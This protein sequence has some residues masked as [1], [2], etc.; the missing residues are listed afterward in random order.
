MEVQNPTGCYIYRGEIEEITV[1]GSELRV[2][3]ARLAKGQGYPSFP[4]RW[5]RHYDLDLAVNLG[6]YEVDVHNKRQ[7]CLNSSDVGESIFLFLPDD[8]NKLDFSRVE[9]PEPD[10]GGGIEA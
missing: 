5:V 1:R 6:I 8:G 4:H 2:K 9:E 10:D 3:F 7:L